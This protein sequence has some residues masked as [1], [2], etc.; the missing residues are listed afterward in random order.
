[1]ILLAVALFTRPTEAAMPEFS[2][3][4]HVIMYTADIRRP[5]KVLPGLWM[6]SQKIRRSQQSPPPCEACS[7]ETCVLVEGSAFAPVLDLEPHEVAGAL[8]SDF[9]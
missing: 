2:D 5:C 3:F 9:A 8:A 7:C 1:M 6:G 4:D